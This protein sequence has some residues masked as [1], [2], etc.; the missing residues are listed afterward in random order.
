MQAYPTA[1][2]MPNRKMRKSNRRKIFSDNKGSMK[3]ARVARREA[4]GNK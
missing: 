3:A 1:L 4:K 2:T